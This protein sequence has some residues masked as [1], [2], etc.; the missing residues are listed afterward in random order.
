MGFDPL[1]PESWETAS[2]GEFMKKVRD[3]FFL[4]P[5][6]TPISLGWRKDVGYV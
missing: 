6:M 4:Q 5:E 2:K 1:K 3:S